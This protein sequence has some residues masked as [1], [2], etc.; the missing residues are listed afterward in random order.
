[1][2]ERALFRELVNK[3]IKFLFEEGG[4]GLNEANFS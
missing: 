4:N 1:M 3:I 2:V